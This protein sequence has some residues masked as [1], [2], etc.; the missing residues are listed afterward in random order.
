[1]KRFSKIIRVGGFKKCS[2]VLYVIN[3]QQNFTSKTNIQ[4]N[5]FKFFP[6]SS[7]IKEIF[8]SNHEILFEQILQSISPIYVQSSY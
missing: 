5:G 4:I 6:P 7:L 1:M 3:S 2:V 8:N